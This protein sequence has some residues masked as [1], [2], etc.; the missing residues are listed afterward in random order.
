[1]RYN[2]PAFM[3]RDD[4]KISVVFPDLPGCLTFS[5]SV[6]EAFLAAQEALE[7]HLAVMADEG[8]KIPEPSDLLAVEPD[9]DE[10]PNLAAKVLVPVTVPGKTVRTNITIDEGLLELVDTITANRSQ[11]FTEAARNELARRRGR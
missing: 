7:G 2:Y 11:F 3:L 8:M 1:M 5:D 6:T 9:E 10:A 4:G